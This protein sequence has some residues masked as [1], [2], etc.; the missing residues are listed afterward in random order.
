MLANV[1]MLSEE[2]NSMLEFLDKVV[3]GD[4]EKLEQLADSYKEDAS[5][6]ADVSSNL[7]AGTEELSA[8]VQNINELLNQISD[9]Q[10]EL[11]KTVQHVNDNMQE[12]TYAS[13]DMAEETREVLDS[14]GSL[15]ETVSTFSV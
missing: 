2:S 7:G 11:N 5:F 13:A 14:V 9:A 3:M 12:I 10:E 8:S 15:Q 6:Y 4:Y 1:A